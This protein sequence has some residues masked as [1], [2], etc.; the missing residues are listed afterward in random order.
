MFCP[1][2]GRQL[3]G[4]CLIQLLLLIYYLY[5]EL[6]NLPPPPPINNV[7]KAFPEAGNKTTRK[8]ILIQTT[9]PQNPIEEQQLGTFLLL[10]RSLVLFGIREVN[11]K[12]RNHQGCTRWW[13]NPISVTEVEEERISSVTKKYT[14][15]FEAQPGR[16]PF[17]IVVVV[18]KNEPNA[19]HQ[20]VSDDLSFVSG[21]RLDGG[22]ECGHG[23]GEDLRNLCLCQEE[24]ADAEVATRKV[25]RI[26]NEEDPE[27]PDWPPDAT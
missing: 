18:H 11:L 23:L 16:I 27:H 10:Q 19:T 26:W 7:W 22:R 5:S 12:I 6:G 15:T 13:A 8:W 14:L 20:Y 1:R 21:R 3:I 25:R 24:K 2:I 17:E 4:I 9:V